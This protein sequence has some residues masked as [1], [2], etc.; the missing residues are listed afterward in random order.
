MQAVTTPSSR[1]YL[2][3]A[4]APVHEEITADDLHVEGEIPGT[5]RGCSSATDPTPV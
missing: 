3:G 2:E 4:Y 5:S 1:P